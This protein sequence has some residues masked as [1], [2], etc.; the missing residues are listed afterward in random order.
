MYATHTHHFIVTTSTVKSARVN[1]TLPGPVDE[2]L[3]KV[4]D[5]TGLS[6]SAAIAAFLTM[7][8]PGLKRWLATVDAP[9]PL[10]S[11]PLPVATGRTAS[12]RLLK[13]A[14]PLVRP[15]M[16]RPERR[17]LEREQRKAERRLK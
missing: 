5:A 8:M 3:G 9:R 17:Q 11:P 14:R 15:V 10:V 7:H 2:L 13:P 6:K 4:A 1:L 16:S 12:G